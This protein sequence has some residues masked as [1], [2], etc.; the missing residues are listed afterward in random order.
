MNGIDRLLA[1]AVLSFVRNE[2]S[3]ALQNLR[4]SKIGRTYLRL[5]TGIMGNLQK[6]SCSENARIIGSVLR[7]AYGLDVQGRKQCC[8][9]EISIRPLYERT[10]VE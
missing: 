8:L 10:K 2:N 9:S 4:G 6:Y 7:N 5:F 3:G 1:F